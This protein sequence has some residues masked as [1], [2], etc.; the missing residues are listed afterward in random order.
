MQL[1]PPTVVLR[2]RRENLKKCSLSGL[3]SRADFKFY[4]YPHPELPDLTGYILL[5]LDAPP[6]TRDDASH[7]IFLLDATWRYAEKM[8]Q[9]AVQIPGLIP[10]SIPSVF[11]TAYPRRQDDC[12]DPDRGLASI[13]ALYVAYVLL[14]RDPSHLLENY[15]WRDQFLDKN[16]NFLV[17]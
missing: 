15:Y 4:A 14:G 10:R 16:K 5:T 6:L 13:E 7:G 9:F 8:L 3:E 11:R 12:H 17:F 2:H 1:F